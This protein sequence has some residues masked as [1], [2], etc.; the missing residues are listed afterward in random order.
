MDRLM[1]RLERKLGRFAIQNLT[2]YIVG[3]MAIA[4]VLALT[5]P[6]LLDAITLNMA[7]VR[8]GQ[9][10]R[11]VTFLFLPPDSS[12]L[13]V[14]VSLYFSWMIGTNIENEW[15]AFKFNAY[16]FFGA[17]CTVLAAVVFGG[18]AGNYFLNTSLFLAFATLFPNME[19]RLFFVIPIRIKWL[20]I[21]S[22]LYLVF[23]F[24][25]GGWATRGAVLAGV[26]NYLVFFSSYFLELLR[27]RNAIVRQTARR[28]EMRGSTP[29]LALVQDRS[30]AICGKRQADGAD[31]RV[32]TCERCGGVA[33]NLC[34]EHAR[35][36]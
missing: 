6:A 24:V 31:I 7:A 27:E 32:C 18:S 36:H 1:T 23:S 3:G 28:V 30:C 13:W 35:A 25:V 21:A 2:Y 17:L 26:A 12:P 15:G 33:R 29:P 9:V 34:L 4:W 16:Y 20:G 22:G 5:R 8:A 19:I 10:W 11:L 14:F